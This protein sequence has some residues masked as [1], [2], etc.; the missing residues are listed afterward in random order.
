MSY[1]RT[2]IILPP[3]INSRALKLRLGG[4]LLEELF[5]FGVSLGGITILSL[6]Y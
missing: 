3:A 5:L 6:T 2:V 4:E 1:R